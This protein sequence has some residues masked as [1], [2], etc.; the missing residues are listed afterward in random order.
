MELKI[1]TRLFFVGI[2]AVLC[3]FD[4]ISTFFA[5]K[6]PGV[7][8]SNMMIAP[9]LKWGLGGY[10]ISYFYLTILALIIL[11][12]IECV[13]WIAK[14]ISRENIQER[15]YCYSCI[16][17]SYVLSVMQCCAIFQ[18]LTLAFL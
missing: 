10:I 11:A 17:V 3:A 5:L 6:M 8:E 18:N 2:F 4:M 1:K 15:F 7:R 14:I 12:V 13:F 16:V 9:I